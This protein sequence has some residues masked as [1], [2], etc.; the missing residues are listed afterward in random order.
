MNIQYIFGNPVRKVTARGRVA[1]RKKSSNLKRKANPMAKRKKKIRR[2]KKKKNPTRRWIKVPGKPPRSVTTAKKK[3]LRS[4]TKAGVMA[5][6]KGEKAKSQKAKK[7]YAAVARK[8]LAAYKKLATQNKLAAKK[9]AELRGAGGKVVKTEHIPLGRKPKKRKAAKPMAKRRKKRKAVKRKKARRKKTFRKKVTLGV[10]KALKTGRS[11]VAGKFRRK[12]RSYAVRAKRV[13]KSAYKKIQVRRNPNGVGG[14]LQKRLAH[15]SAEAL[16]LL[17]GGASYGAINAF[18]LGTPALANIVSKI[19]SLPGGAVVSRVIGPS[20]PPLVLG[21]ALQA[22]TQSR[23]KV[24]GKALLSKY[25]KGLIGAAVVA[26][27]ANL[28][29]S[30]G[31]LAKMAGFPTMRGIPSMRGVDYT[32]YSGVDYTPYSGVDYTPYSGDAQQLGQADFG[33]ADQQL[34]QYTEEDP[35]RAT[36]P[37]D[38]G[39]AADFG[40]AADSSDMGDGVQQMG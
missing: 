14:F 28:S 34:G 12:K 22:L 38:F 23:I 10:P 35:H 27:G 15:T 18:V 6:R 29:E 30:V 5:K 1:K 25:A 4:I 36:E 24:P 3:E 11:A 13:R 33:M 21:A 39:Q 19:D 2:K 32:P 20:L 9:I 40:H 26:V 8:S 16:S 31:G 17:A 7:R 37:A